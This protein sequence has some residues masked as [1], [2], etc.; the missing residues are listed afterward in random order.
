MFLL[1]KRIL[2]AYKLHIRASIIT[3]WLSEYNIHEALKTFAKFYLKNRSPKSIVTAGVH[4]GKTTHV[5]FIQ[6]KRYFPKK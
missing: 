1:K 6:T 3:H 4:Y 2:R 5:H